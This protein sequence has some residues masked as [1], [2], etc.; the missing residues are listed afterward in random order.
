LKVS[1]KF[2][3]VYQSVQKISD[4]HSGHVAGINIGER[5]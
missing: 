3:Y 1:T 2:V 5:R 4:R